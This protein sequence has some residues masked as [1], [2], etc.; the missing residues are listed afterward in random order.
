MPLIVFEG[1]T[2]A[3]EKKRQLVA[4]FVKAASGVTGIRPEA[5]TTVIHENV[6]ENIG[7]GTELLAD[8]FARERP[9]ATA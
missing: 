5:F 8:R 4:A 1:P 6:P 2:L 3:T 9:P 7:T